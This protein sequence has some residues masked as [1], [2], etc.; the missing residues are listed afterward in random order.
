MQNTFFKLSSNILSVVD[1]DPAGLN[2]EVGSGIPSRIKNG[3]VMVRYHDETLFFLPVNNFI[4]HDFNKGRGEYSIFGIQVN[5]I[6]KINNFRS[7][8]FSVW[9][10]NEWIS[11]VEDHKS[12]GLEYGVC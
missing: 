9:I 5:Q 8:S 4:D 6:I 10:H 3:H 12:V 11:P 2:Y 1:F 7:N